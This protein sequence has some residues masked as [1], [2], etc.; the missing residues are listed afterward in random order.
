[1]LDVAWPEVLVVGAVALIA[2]GPKDMPK[3]MYALGRWARKAVVFGREM[4]SAFDEITIEAEAS[5]KENKPQRKDF[6]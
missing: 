3:V 5:D 2:I 4:R 1:M 6:R